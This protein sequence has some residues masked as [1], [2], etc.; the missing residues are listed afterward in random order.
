VRE[1]GSN[2]RSAERVRERTLVSLCGI[3]MIITISLSAL[4]CGCSDANSEARELENSGD[5]QGALAVYQEVLESEPDNLSALSG[6]AVALTVLRRYDEALSLQ[7]RVV[8]ADPDDAQTRVELGFNYL[9][10]QGR[11]G[12]AVRV[13]TEAVE[14]EPSAKHLTFLAQAKEEAGDPYG[15]EQS[16]RKAIET[17]PVYGY[18]YGQLAELL[19]EEGRSGDVAQLIEDARSWGVVV[20]DPR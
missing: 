13:L 9:S 2:L 11:A 18:A 1:P 17:D 10:H 14:L 15:A 5:W 8:V 19:V 20:V 3:A 16:L 7:E 4:A 12:D 6:A